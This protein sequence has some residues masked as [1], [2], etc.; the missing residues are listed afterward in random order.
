[1]GQLGR[2]LVRRL[3]QEKEFVRLY[4]RRLP[5]KEICNHPQV[6]V[7]LGELGDQE[8]VDAA[9]AGATAVF[10]LG[11]AMGGGWAAHEAATIAGTRNVV[12]ACLK[13]EVPK[14]IYISS[15]S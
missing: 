6:E 9:L 4:V 7:V 3:I 12:E 2:A 13:Y 8:A 1:N 5:P 11:A 10:H 14:M 15:L